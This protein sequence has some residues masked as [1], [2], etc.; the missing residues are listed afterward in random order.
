MIRQKSR[1]WLFRKPEPGIPQS[2]FI[3]IV[4]GCGAH[5]RQAVDFSSISRTKVLQDISPFLKLK[6]GMLSGNR[7]KGK[8]N[9]A[10]L[11]T[12]DACEIFTV[13]RK[14]YGF[15]E[16]SGR[17]MERRGMIP[18]NHATP[19]FIFNPKD[20]L[21]ITYKKM[22]ISAFPQKDRIPCRFMIWVHPPQFLFSRILSKNIL[23][24]Y[25]GLRG[26]FP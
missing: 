7:L 1:R 6:Q 11:V 20:R 22:A 8:H 23:S 16:P 21:P 2:D 9:L 15:S 13:L 24:N 5:R 12:S 14:N 3:A 26:S 19:I 17:W 25:S 4:K 10:M 18:G